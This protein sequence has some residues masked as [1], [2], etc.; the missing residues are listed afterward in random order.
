MA[1][2]FIKQLKSR[3]V[4]GIRAKFPRPAL[5]FH[6]AQTLHD[7]ISVSI[8]RD[9]LYLNTIGVR[10]TTITHIGMDIKYA[11]GITTRDYVYKYPL[12]VNPSFYGNCYLKHHLDE[13]NHTGDK[14]EKIIESIIVHGKQR[15]Q[16]SYNHAFENEE[17]FEIKAMQLKHTTN[18][19][20]C[21]TLNEQQCHIL[22][23]IISTSVDFDV[24]Y[25][26]GLGVHINTILDIGA[27]LKHVL[28][29]KIHS[30]MQT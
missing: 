15:N 29:T 20:P 11:I 26:K 27:E 14:M 16:R 7:V 17:S 19:I 25:L 12:S 22:E 9:V 1:V 24:M 28:V 23:E 6:Q 4:K 18:N 5:N 30:Y 2:P 13:L 3:E 8:D 10:M 21:P